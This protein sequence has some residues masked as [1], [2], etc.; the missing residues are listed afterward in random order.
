MA[1][2]I[3]LRRLCNNSNLLEESISCFSTFDLI[4]KNSSKLLTILESGDT[5]TSCTH[6]SLFVKFNFNAYQ[7]FTLELTCHSNM[8]SNILPAPTPLP[9]SSLNIIKVDME[10]SKFDLL[11]SV[12]KLCFVI[13]FMF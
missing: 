2:K 11:N 9:F 10:L 4:D 7:P 8:F 3:Q 1:S 12:K 13:C 5:I 6:Q